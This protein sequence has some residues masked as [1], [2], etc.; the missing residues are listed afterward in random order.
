MTD[1]EDRA[2][3]LA[4]FGRDAGLA[5]AALEQADIAATACPDIE[6]FCAEMQAG[7]AAGVVTHEAL[8]RAASARLLRALSEQPPWSDFPLV[9][10]TARPPT[11]ADRQRLWQTLSPLGGITVLERPVH[12]EA[13]V[14]A[15]R[16][17]VR[18]RRRQYQARELLRCLED[19]VRERDHFLA[20]L[21]HEL[22][23]PLGAIR[24]A[25]QL[26]ARETPAEDGP[27][28]RRLA[29]LDRQTRHLAK[30]VDD[31]LDVA[32]VTTGKVVLQRQP[33]ELGAI[34]EQTLQ[35]LAP[36][37]EEHGL[38]L[39]WS[40]GPPMTV[41][42]DSLRLE[43]I[44][45]NLLTNAIKYTPRGGRVMVTAGI[46]GDRARVRIADT[47]VGIAAEALPTI[48]ELFAQSDQSLDRSQGGMGIGLTL[49][50][51]L[52]DLH[53]GSVSASSGGPGRGS[54]FVVTL[55]L[56]GRQ[57]AT[58]AVERPAADA[59]P[60]GRRILLVEDNADNRETLQELLTER[61]HR[62][63]ASADGLDAIRR[64][65]AL[66][67]EVAI[68]DI[69]LP[70]M[71]GYEVGRRLRDA[72]GREIL[73][74]ALTGYGLPEDRRRAV[75]AGFDVHVTK[76]VGLPELEAIFLRL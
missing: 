59:A 43:Q 68:V 46:D 16:S 29:I 7:A 6:R 51:S 67:P 42:G 24:N 71:D 50:R 58:A 5:V 47:G 32:R 73:L 65:A 8:G 23:N 35:Q 15:V 17:A 41:N 3:V 26:L 64:A 52:L 18:A 54:E 66:Q 30:L 31:L 63:D 2:L 28:R 44:F 10:L 75:A 19:G 53:G 20:T 37:V 70:G 25:T 39:L 4:P 38:K 61:G 11:A 14:S 13:L 74:V 49:V 56:D 9:I 27:T 76:P 48:F 12:A 69:G 62:V 36:A 34:L 60:S 55:P 40:R 45:T 33:V 22:R 21:S 72:F 1:D 57:A